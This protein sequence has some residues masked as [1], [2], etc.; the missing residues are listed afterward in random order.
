MLALI[1]TRHHLMLTFVVLALAALPAG[2]MPS[3]S[4]GQATITLCTGAGM[5]EAW[6]DAEMSQ[7]A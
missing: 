7:L 2:W 6:V 1:R 5:V 4:N 3:V